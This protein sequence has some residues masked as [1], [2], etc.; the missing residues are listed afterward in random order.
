[1][2]EWLAGAATSII[3]GSTTS[4]G[5]L[6]KLQ[7]RMRLRPNAV[8]ERIYASADIA[9]VAAAVAAREAALTAGIKTHGDAV[10]AAYSARAT[11][12]ANAYTAT[13]S[14][15]IRQGVKKA[16]E[17]FDSSVREARKNW[18]T[19]RKNAWQQFRTTIKSC[20]ASAELIDSANESSEPKGE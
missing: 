9:C 14:P 16:W 11:G 6:Q 13:S 18:Q 2:F 19:A 1:M 5:M 7:N 17:A 10:V 12:L 3:I 15:A 4:P 8:K 20:K